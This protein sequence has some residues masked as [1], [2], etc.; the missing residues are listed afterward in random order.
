MVDAP[1]RVPLSEI[2]RELGKRADALVRWLGLA[3]EMRGRTLF[4]LNPT[5][6]DSRPGSF[7]IELHGSNAGMWCDWAT[8]DP[9]STGDAGD[10]LDLIAYIRGVAL[11]E[12]AKQARVF[13]GMPDEAIPGQ[14]RPISDLRPEQTDAARSRMA[15]A[16]WLQGQASLAGTPVA[17]Y[18]AGRGC[19][20]AQ[21]GR[22][23]RA[24][25]FHP[26]LKCS[27]LDDAFLPAMVAAVT[28]GAEHVGT[29]RT[30]LQQI[31][32]KWTRARRPDGRK[33]AKKSYGP[34]SGGHI[35]IWRGASGKPL[36]AAPEGDVVAIAEGIET[37]LSVAIACPE[38]RV[39]SGISLGGM[40]SLALPPAIGTVILCGDNDP[41]RWR[42][43]MRRAAERYLAEGREV[44][45]AV[46][47]VAGADWNDILQG[48]EG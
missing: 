9:R 34:I 4:A 20:L 39:I 6:G 22:Q 18:L 32:G 43:R 46:P 45:I 35:A 47:E 7:Q 38:L 48:V 11:G 23:P 10:A 26:R 33:V 14:R 24:L 44:R 5:R 3:G 31:G 15:Q 28:V 21:L 17:A 29:H 41:D 16:M 19:D 37:A 42:A 40:G 2:A 27:E 30:W 13:L 36:R 12:A 25:R 1:P 8:G